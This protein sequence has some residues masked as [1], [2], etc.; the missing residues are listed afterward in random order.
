MSEQI[1]DRLS[2]I[3]R[4]LHSVFE[5]VGS[6][7]ALQMS[8]DYLRP[9]FVESSPAQRTFVSTIDF[10]FDSILQSGFRK[11]ELYI[12][13]YF[14]QARID[15]LKPIMAKGAKVK[16]ISPD[17]NL[18]RNPDKSNLDALKRMKKYGAEVK[19]HSMCHARIFY[20]NRDDKCEVIIGSGD[21]KSDCLSG[22]RFD[23]GI[24]SD[25]P[26]MI[27]STLDFFN[28]VWDDEGAITLDELGNK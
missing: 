10:I 25:N 21:V 15:K 6:I 3:E 24:Y 22:K 14:D 18:S 17:L 7:Y 13:G 1:V 23:A 19:I 27:R 9:K 28:R 26:D 11:V 12:M 4:E 5:C 2:K 16:I 20:A 8:S